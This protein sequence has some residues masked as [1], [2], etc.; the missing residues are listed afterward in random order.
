MDEPYSMKG[1]KLKVLY[2]C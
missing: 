2:S 1:A